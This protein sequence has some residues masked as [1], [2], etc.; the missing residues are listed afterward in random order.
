MKSRTRFSA[1]APRPRAA[2]IA[3]AGFSSRPPPM[4]VC[5]AICTIAE[6]ENLNVNQC[7]QRQ[8]GDRGLGDL[9]NLRKLRRLDLA[10][11]GLTDK[12][13]AF[14]AAAP[15]PGGTGPLR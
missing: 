3:S 7:A 4:S 2:A 11:A 15:D 8:M 1:R 12:S 6:L 5:G 14:I 10:G 9:K 13:L